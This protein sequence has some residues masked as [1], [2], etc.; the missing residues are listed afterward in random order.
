MPE[1]SHTLAGYDVKEELGRGAFGAVRLVECRKSGEKRAAKFLV[2]KEGEDGDK[3]ANMVSAEVKAL[4]RAAGHE[5]VLSFLERVDDTAFHIV[6][7]ELLVGEDVG[8]R[9]ARVGSGEAIARRTMT[10]LTSAFVHLAEQGLVH[11]DVKPTNLMYTARSP[12]APVKV[13]DFGTAVMVD[14]AD[15]E[16]EYGVAGTLRY[17][18]PEMLSKKPYGPLTDV[19]G[20]GGV[21]HLMLTG[22]DAFPQSQLQKLRAA[23]KGGNVDWYADGWSGICSEAQDLCQGMLCVKVG[24]R[25]TASQSNRHEFLSPGGGLWADRPTGVELDEG[26]SQDDVSNDTGFTLSPTDEAMRMVYADPVRDGAAEDPSLRYDFAEEITRGD[27]GC[28][29]VAICKRSGVRRAARFLRHSDSSSKVAARAEAEVKA[30]QCAGEH[31]HV[32]AFLEQFDDAVH[33][34]IVTELIVG[35]DIGARIARL[36]RS[37]GL[38]RRIMPQL[39]SAFSHLSDCGVIHRDVKAANLVF[40]TTKS[41]APVKVSGFSLALCVDPGDPEGEYGVAGTLRYMSPEM[42]SKKPYG[43]LTDVWGLGGVLHLMLTGTDAFPQNQLQKLRAAV[44]EGNVD[45]SAD[46]W[47]GVCSEAQDLCQGM[48]CVELDERISAARGLEHRFVRD[49]GSLWMDCC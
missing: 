32:L 7:T 47:S 2:R 3:Q 4:Q 38:A 43:P 11:R 25:M 36:G 40:A 26:A 49:G 8:A 18:S 34:V 27:F 14:P 39:L 9:I 35:E 30:L 6:V 5:H 23:V 46:G 22:T 19:W 37:E 41:D 1:Q 13:I 33:H 16:G 21:L 31:E 45:W 24:R 29:R 10:Q 15:P 17:M 12:D 28:S 44:K 42:L 20:L 48:L